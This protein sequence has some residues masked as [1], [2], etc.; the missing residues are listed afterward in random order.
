MM[1]SILEK[2]LKQRVSKPAMNKWS[3]GFTKTK[4]FAVKNK[5]P[6]IAVWSEGDNCGHCANAMQSFMMQ[7]FKNW[8]A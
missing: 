3:S 5:V 1:A 7:S 4:E 8:M 6:L 2:F